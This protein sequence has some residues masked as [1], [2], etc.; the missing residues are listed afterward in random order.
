MTN[1]EK[2]TALEYFLKNDDLTK[3]LIED[4]TYLYADEMIILISDSSFT[5][6]F[7]N[8]FAAFCEL[9]RINYI[10]NANKITTL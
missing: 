2:L 4:F 7:I 1:T 6:V 9:Y 3:S 10:I 5:C 8:R